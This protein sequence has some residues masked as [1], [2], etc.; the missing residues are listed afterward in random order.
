M[1]FIRPAI[2]STKEF[3]YFVPIQRSIYLK[4]SLIDNGDKD[5]IN[6]EFPL[7]N[8]N[9]RSFSNNKG[10][11]SYPVESK[12]DVAMKQQKT[13]LNTKRAISKQDDI[14]T[15]RTSTE[16]VDI[17]TDRKKAIAKQDEIISTKNEDIRTENAENKECS[18]GLSSFGIIKKDLRLMKGKLPPIE[19]LIEFLGLDNDKEY[20]KEYIKKYLDNKEVQKLLTIKGTS[21]VMTGIVENKWNVYVCRLLS[22]VLDISFIYRKAIVNLSD[23]KGESYAI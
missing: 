16:N 1:E 4:W 14:P 5:V 10:F 3:D 21:S 20:I 15:D 12:Q 9:N 22:Y 18:N 7:C 2:D 23:Y 6:D 11:K 17:R 19:F 8:E 13:I